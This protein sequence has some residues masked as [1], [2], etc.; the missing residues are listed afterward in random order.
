[1]AAP[2]LTFGGHTLS[3]EDPDLV[4]V[5]FDG[6]VDLKQ[7][8]EMNDLVREFKASRGTIYLVADARKGLGFSAEA[9]KAVSDDPKLSPYAATAFFGA[10]FA[11]KT[12]VNMLNRA[13]ALM[14]RST[15][16]VM[17]FVDTE[18]EARAW[19]AKQRAAAAQKAS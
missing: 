12:I 2:A 11:M 18:E 5:V 13:M 17:T 7:L 19:V 3:F 14:G 4:R 15:G 6:E 8:Y 10:S 16:G 1:M 9:R